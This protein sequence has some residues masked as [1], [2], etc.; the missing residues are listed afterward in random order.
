M[1][2]SMRRLPAIL[3]LALLL[4]AP[5]FADSNWKQSQT[6]WSRMDKC[7]REARRQFPDYTA[8]ANAKREIARQRCLRNGNLP[9]ETD[10]QPQAVE[11]ASR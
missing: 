10:P 1:M 11:P 6:V 3:L 9:G 8:E 5:A 2:L 7:T 4:P